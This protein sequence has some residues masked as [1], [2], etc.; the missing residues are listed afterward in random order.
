MKEW[1]PGRHLD[2]PSKEGAVPSRLA[3]LGFR[4]YCGDVSLSLFKAR[5]PAVR[6]DLNSALPFPSESFDY[7]T[8][9][10][11]IEHLERPFDALGEISRVLRPAGRLILSTPNVLNLRSRWRFLLAGHHLRFREIRRGGHILALSYRELQYFLK[12]HGFE[13]LEITTDRVRRKSWPFHLILKA[14]CR[15]SARRLNPFADVINREP[16]VSGRTIII[17]AEKRG[18]ASRGLSRQ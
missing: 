5:V 10:E 8:F 3:E 11:G 13:I 7:V 17:V 15:Y 6:L 16:L 4:S 14:I 2:I 1:P 18:N 9:I 12:L